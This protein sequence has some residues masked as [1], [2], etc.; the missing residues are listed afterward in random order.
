MDELNKKYFDEMKKCQR[1]WDLEKGIPEEHLESLIYAAHNAPKKNLVRFF[2]LLVV[3]TRE[4]IDV[5]AGVTGPIKG[6]PDN[7]DAITQPKQSQMY[8]NILF[9][10]IYDKDL[11]NFYLEEIDDINYND[12]NIQLHS[13]ISAGMVAYEAHR[14]GYKT[15]FCLCYQHTKDVL[16]Q[17]NINGEV[18]LF[19]GVGHDREDA[20]YWQPI[21]SNLTEEGQTYPY[22]RGDIINKNTPNIGQK[23]VEYAPKTFII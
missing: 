17:Y 13:G 12:R 14:L 20:P 10:W 9:G 23:F 19:L 4:I 15:G 7:P 8:A 22:G 1:N 5:F 11:K 2:S 6:G 16:S 3:R 18:V 21:I